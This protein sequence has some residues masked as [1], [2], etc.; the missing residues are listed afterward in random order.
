MLDALAETLAAQARGAL[1]GTGRAAMADPAARI[2]GVE[3][4]LA[5]RE[6]AQGNVNPQL[7]LAVL[8]DDLAMLEA[9]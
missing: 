3:R 1:V 2:A 4:V 9:A 6:Q 5:A 7:L 8:A